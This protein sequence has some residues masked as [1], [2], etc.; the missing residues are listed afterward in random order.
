MFEYIKDTITLTEIKKTLLLNKTVIDIE[1]EAFYYSKITLGCSIV[2][3]LFLGLGSLCVF[4][5]FENIW[6]FLYVF[7]MALAI[8]YN[9]LNDTIPK[10]LNTR[11]IFILK[12]KQLYYTQQNQWYNI[13]ECH[14]SIDSVGKYNY[15]GTLKIH[16]YLD[17]NNTISENIW[18]I[19]NDDTLISRI[20]KI[21]GITNF[22]DYEQERQSRK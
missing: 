8:I 10:Y 2:F 22:F 6:L 16:S 9:L 17:S 3:Q 19:S 13:A 11:P 1:G 20:K 5:F 18:H 12:Q 4:P 14:V 21:K 7:L 15:S